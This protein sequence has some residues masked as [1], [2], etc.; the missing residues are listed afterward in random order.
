M[1]KL[2]TDL[3]RGASGADALERS[4]LAVRIILHLLS[5][6]S[7]LR[8]PPLDLL[9]HLPLFLLKKKKKDTSQRSA[10]LS[11]VSRRRRVFGSLIK[12]CG[13]FG[14]KLEVR[15]GRKWGGFQHFSLMRRLA[16]FMLTA[17]LSQVST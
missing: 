7:C 1:K 4:L 9:L 15:G 8:S 6:L 17:R 12:L 10:R 2:G 14:G 16:P 13:A 3:Q 5:L 11:R